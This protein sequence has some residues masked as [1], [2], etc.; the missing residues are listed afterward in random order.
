MSIHASI[1]K[2]R[3]KMQAFEDL[4]TVS[5]VQQA[6]ILLHLFILRK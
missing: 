5:T 6:D 3:V 2:T 4:Q 1:I